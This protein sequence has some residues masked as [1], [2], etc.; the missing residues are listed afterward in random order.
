MDRQQH[1][2]EP[3]PRYTEATLIKALEDH[4]IGRPSTYAAT[5]STIVDRGYVKVKERR[6][7]PEPVGEIVTDLLVC[8]F[9]EFVDLEFTARMEEELDDVASGKRAWVPVVRE[10]Y[11]PFRTRIEEKTKEL[12]RADFTTRPSDEVCSQGHPMVIRLG[13]YGEFLACSMYPEHKETRE[14]PGA[15]GREPGASAVGLDGTPAKPAAA[16]AC[17]RCGEAEGGVLVARRGRFGPFMGCSRYPDCDYIKKDGPPPPDPLAFDVACPTCH[18]GKLTTRR[19]RRTGS[20]FWGCSRY[21]KCDYTTSHEPLG[22][23][24]RRGRRAGRPGRRRGPLPGLRRAVDCRPATISVGQA[25]GGRRAESRGAGP[26]QLQPRAATNPGQGHGEWRG[27]PSLCHAKGRGDPQLERPPRRMNSGAGPGDHGAAAAVERFLQA[28]RARGSSVHTIRSYRTALDVYTGWLS[29]NGHDW[30][31]PSRAALRAFLGSL[32]EGHG[33][34]TVAQR[35]A[36]VRSFYRFATREELV[37][38]QS[39]GGPANA[40]A[41]TPAAGGPFDCRD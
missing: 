36:A 31:A 16:E 32:S 2:T 27:I 40:P 7:H 11:A 19:A 38:G 25:A 39:A 5:I 1:F 33:R 29:A 13:R 8:H 37:A 24:P 21:P 30:R 4:G 28:L 26:A 23:R 17:P 6:L 3:P 35:L 15:D 41:A 20:L 22:R 12:R 10:F 9:G 14:L 18:Q 34:R